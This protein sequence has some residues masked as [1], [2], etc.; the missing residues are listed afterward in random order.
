MEHFKLEDY[1]DSYQLGSI[2]TTELC[3][4]NQ[5]L[6]E[7]GLDEDNTRLTVNPGKQFLIL[8]VMGINLDFAMDFSVLSKPSWL[9]DSGRGSISVDKCDMRLNL[10]PF[11]QDGVL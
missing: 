8:D 10:H 7:F 11:T 2:L 6:V 1:C 4:S 3:L 5:E 9:K